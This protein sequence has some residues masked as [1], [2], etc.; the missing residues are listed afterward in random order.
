MSGVLVLSGNEDPTL[1]DAA[2]EAMFFEVQKCAPYSLALDADRPRDIGNRGG[3]IMIDFAVD[4]AA[5]NDKGVPDQIFRR[6][7]IKKISRMI[8]R[9]DNRR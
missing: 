1:I 6:R 7:Q 8:V 2:D 4:I 9:F 5:S 3:I